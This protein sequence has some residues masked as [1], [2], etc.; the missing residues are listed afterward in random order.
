MTSVTLS[1]LSTRAQLLDAGR[2]II[3][4]Q[5][6]QRLT[7]REIA[8]LSGA[9][10]GSFVYHFRTRDTF[11]RTLLEE[12]YAPLQSRVTVAADGS[13]T[14]LERLRRAILELV[15]FGIEHGALVG[16]L[17]TGA[18]GGEQAAHDFLSTLAGRHPRLLLRLICAAQAEDE[19]VEERPLQVLC[20]I[21]ASVGL[22]LLLDGAWHGP[23]PFGKSFSAMLTRVARDRDS[24]VQRL[25]WAIRGLNPRGQ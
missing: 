22:P 3:L 21:M 16:R 19:L 18:A 1:C 11:I 5:G 4:R 12:W 17:V 10:L 20:F 25:D 14:P 13:G 6:F 7:V 23:P 15:D 24:V 9:N 2:E 8:A